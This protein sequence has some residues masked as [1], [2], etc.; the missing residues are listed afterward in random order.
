MCM[1]ANAY[2]PEADTLFS[3]NSPEILNELHERVESYGGQRCSSRGL[4]KEGKTKS[5]LRNVLR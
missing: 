1:G 2:F 3:G 5:W 4:L